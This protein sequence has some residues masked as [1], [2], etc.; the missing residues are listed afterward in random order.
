MSSSKRKRAKGK[1]AGPST[2]KFSLQ[3]LLTGFGIGLILLSLFLLFR[4]FSDPVKNELS[5][6]V[7]TVSPVTRELTPPNTDFALVIDKLGAASAIISEVD[8]GNSLAYQRALTRGVAHAKGTKYPG[9]G[10]N[11]FLF[12]HS[13]ADLLTAERY[14]SVF[15]L[16]HHFEPGD[17]IKVWYR[18]TKHNYAVFT[19]KIVSPGDTSYL[20]PY[21]PSEQLTLM[22]CWPPGTTLKRLIIIARPQ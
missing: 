11:I 6:A 22:T 20:T 4:L 1:K 17:L 5:Y 7:R 16:M 8:A 9:Q 15:Y 21:A 3:G 19:K 13:S 14:N 10:G 12:A 18:G 2:P